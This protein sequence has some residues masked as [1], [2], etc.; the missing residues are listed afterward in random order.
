MF[1]SAISSIPNSC[2]SRQYG[3]SEQAAGHCWAGSLANG[4]SKRWS[5][6]P[7]HARWH[8]HNNLA[9]QEEALLPRWSIRTCT[10]E[11]QS[12]NSS[13]TNCCSGLLFNRGLTHHKL[14]SRTA[15]RET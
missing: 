6:T 15:R 3:E 4:R 9:S 8:R 5:A 1:A 10:G 11:T 2:R 14:E 12:T 13:Q 7:L